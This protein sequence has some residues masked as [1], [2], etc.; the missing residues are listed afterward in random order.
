MLR[1][2]PVRFISS[3]FSDQSVEKDLSGLSSSGLR[4]AIAAAALCLTG[5]V[6][7]VNPFT[8]SDIRVEGVERV[9]PSTIFNYLPVH[10]G[11]TFTDE[12]GTEAIRSLYGTGLFKDVRVEAQGSVMVV[13]VQERPVIGGIDFDGTKEFEKA[14]LGKA[15][16]DMGVIEARAYDRSA[17]SR[18]EQELKRQY[19]SWLL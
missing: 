8:I 14:Q 2:V 7:A 16:K 15:L 1:N 3:K 10:V 13:S 4:T 17:V 5:S 12:K 9:E 18:A 11:D 19:I 6:L